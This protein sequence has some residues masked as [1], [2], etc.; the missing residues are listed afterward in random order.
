MAR[1]E[2]ELHY[3][4][5]YQWHRYDCGEDLAQDELARAFSLHDAADSFALRGGLYDQPARL[6][7]VRRVGSYRLGRYCNSIR[8]LAH[9]E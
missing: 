5:R 2:L 1:R 9:N 6:A 4:G 8:L 7:I 3:L